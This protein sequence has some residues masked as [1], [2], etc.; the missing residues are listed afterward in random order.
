MLRQ[1]GENLDIGGWEALG[2]SG[3]VATTGE[4][5]VF[6][7]WKAPGS[8]GNVVTTGGNPG[9]Q[10]LESSWQQGQCCDNGGKSWDS[11]ALKAPGAS[12][13]RTAPAPRS[14]LFLKFGCLE[15]W[16]SFGVG[17]PGTLGRWNRS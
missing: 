12:G 1:R 16:A 15:F 13:P 8:R 9:F 2:S 14:D 4:I 7:G 6:R 3:N 11:E 17:L 5:L 10:R